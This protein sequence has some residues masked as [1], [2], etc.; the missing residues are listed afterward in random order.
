M[1]LEMGKKY[2]VVDEVCVYQGV[3]DNLHQFVPEN[4]G[5]PWQYFIRLAI[6]L[7]ASAVAN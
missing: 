4:G 7:L 5:E 6:Y 1:K 3:S 2:I